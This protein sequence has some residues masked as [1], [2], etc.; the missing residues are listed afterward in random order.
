M[1]MSSNLPP[2]KTL[3]S[4]APWR[5]FQATVSKI[6]SASPRNRHDLARRALHQLPDTAG[7]DH[8]AL[9]RIGLVVL[10]DLVELVEIVDHEP[11]RLLEPFVGDIA[12]EIQPL[13]P[14]AVAEVEAGDLIGRGAMRGAP[15][16]EIPGGGA[17][18]R[19]LDGIA[20]V[21]VLP[22]VRAVERRKRRAILSCQRPR[23]FAQA[24]A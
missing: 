19:V 7:R 22:P 21:G 4:N 8:G 23:G 14:C 24:L 6:S 9:L 17:Q 10:L 1:T 12:E 13:E 3:N 5:L 11:V 20:G 2:M 16:Q 18:Q 15:A